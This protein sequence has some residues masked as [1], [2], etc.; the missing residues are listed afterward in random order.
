MAVTAV[1][2]VGRLLRGREVQFK[3]VAIT[4]LCSY[5]LQLFALWLHWALWAVA[6]ATIIPWI[7]LFT[8][9]V[10]WTSKHYGFMAIYLVIM[11]L[12]AGHVGEHIVQMLQFIF[13]YNPAHGCFGWNWYGVCSEAHGVFGELDRELVHFVW[14]GLILVATIVVRLHFRHVKNPWMTAA[15]IAAA[16]HQVEH[17]YLF[18]IYLFLPALYHN[19]GTF[20]GVHIINGIA[21]QN[22]LMGHN[23]FVGSLT[24]INGPINAILPSRIN[25]HF[26]YNTFVFIPMV[27]AFRS[28]VRYVYDEW[29]AKAMPQLSEE[30]LIAATAQSQNET[31]PADHIIFRQG[32]PAD[33]FY[34]I[35]RGQVDVVRMDK[36]SGQETQ[37]ARLAEGQ[38]FGEI[39]L[40]GRTE[41][42]ATIK[43]VTPVE[44]L[45][46]ERAVFRS[47]MAASGEAYKDMDL[48]LRRRLVQLGALQGVALQDTV[49]ADPDTILK[50]RMI[51]DR[52]KLLQGDDVS[53]ILGHSHVPVY[54]PAAA[55]PQWPPAGVA[56][57]ERPV[58]YSSEAQGTSPTPVVARPIGNGNASFQRGAL[59]V[60]TGPSAGMRYEINAPRIIVGRRSPT[61]SAE[62]PM[63]QIDDGRVSRH[64][65]EVF[66]QADGLYARD[67]GSANGTWLNS[68]QLGGEP[69][70]LNDGDELLVGP[71]STLNF[72]VN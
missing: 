60:R 4:A 32:D 5:F 48:V 65:L 45:V 23:G 18:G 8:M 69:V 2:Q 30:Q 64:H 33:K 24:S 21:A 47:L 13:I 28:Q 53:R 44:C 59:V 6:L 17:C 25:L 10:L 12:Q 70:R 26:I 11:V 20:L 68:R 66:V 56:V 72:R 36:R 7:P 31:F 40:L 19:G 46:L 58:A 51:R 71:D 37:V 29:L 1:D 52:L 55:A 27:F 42:T 39:G 43:T 50:T 41:R 67:L 3:A 49:N 63:M 22:G 9:K 38:Y 15:I 61:V 14:D 62:V 35:T 34:I 54:A 57:A 16:I